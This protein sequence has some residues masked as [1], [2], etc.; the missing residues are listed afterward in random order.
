M[1]KW[2]SAE[3]DARKKKGRRDKEESYVLDERMQVFLL[4]WAG[5]RA[6]EKSVKNRS[7]MEDEIRNSR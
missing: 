5:G 1:K 6:R 7:E 4:F 3:K 2:E